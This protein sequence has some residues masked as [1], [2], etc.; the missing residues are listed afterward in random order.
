[1]VT[2]ETEALRVK[3]RQLR[4][5]VEEDIRELQSARRGLESTPTRRA[6]PDGVGRVGLLALL[7]VL[8]AWI[9]GLPSAALAG[10]AGVAIAVQVAIILLGPSG[11]HSE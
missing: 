1:M 7:L 8:V 10:I 9:V 5:E 11:R 6:V 4:L 2:P 3:V